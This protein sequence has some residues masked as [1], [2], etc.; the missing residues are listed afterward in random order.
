MPKENTIDIDLVINKMHER[1]AERNGNK[2]TL[3]Q[4]KQNLQETKQYQ[5]EQKYAGAE[6]DPQAGKEPTCI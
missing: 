4:A 5:A 1:R 3:E 6:D 2:H